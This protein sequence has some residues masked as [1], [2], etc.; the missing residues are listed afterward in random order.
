[1]KISHD[2][3]HAEFSSLI[4]RFAAERI[5]LLRT[6]NSHSLYRLNSQNKG[7]ILKWY[8]SSA[9]SLESKIYHLL[10]EYYVPTLPAYE[11]NG[12]ALVLEDLQSSPSW[13]LADQS[14]MAHME[15]GM[16]VAEW[17]LQLH[18]AGREALKEDHWR[19]LSIN[20]WVEDISPA[21]LEKAA[22]VFRIEAEPAWK[23]ATTHTQALKTKYLSLP[24]TFNYNDF[25]AENLALSRAKEQPLQ[26]IV[27][28]Y[29]WFATGTAYSDWR[30]VMASLRDAARIGFQEVY[31]PIALEEKLLDAPLATLYGLVV[32]SQRDK[33]PSWAIPL[34][35]SVTNGELEKM[36]HEALS[37]G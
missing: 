29:D 4:T 22:K 33:I 37:A 10:D 14:D 26:V 36:V 8:V 12:R 25:A 16:A 9:Q 7:Y 24:Q 2:W 20:P 6:S 3:D 17:Y 23:T 28:D 15:T 13:R 21:S 31:G 19:Q 5:V 30:N 1:M 32:A 27:F 34:A 18:R 35:D 11:N